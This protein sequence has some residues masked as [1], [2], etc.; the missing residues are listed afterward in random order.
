MD[1]T[2]DRGAAGTERTTLAAYLK[3]TPFSH[4]EEAELRECLENGL[5]YQGG[6][7]ATPTGFTPTFII[8]TM[9]D[10]DRE[11]KQ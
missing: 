10:Y 3:V 7:V 4:E 5:E 2:I 6:G 8:F 1:I 11:S 9:D